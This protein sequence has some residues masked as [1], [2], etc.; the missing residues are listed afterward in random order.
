MS[1]AHWSPS[2]SHA[3]R[4]IRPPSMTAEGDDLTSHEQSLLEL[5]ADRRSSCSP[6]TL[7]DELMTPPGQRVRLAGV[8]TDM[9][10]ARFRAAPA[11]ITTVD[12]LS[13]QAECVDRIG[14]AAQRLVAPLLAATSHLEAVGKALL[15][16]GSFD[17]ICTHLPG[18]LTAL[19]H[20]Y[21]PEGGVDGEGSQRN[22][23]IGTC[24]YGRRLQWRVTRDLSSQRA[25]LV[26]MLRQI[27]GVSV[28]PQDQL[29][30]YYASGMLFAVGDDGPQALSWARS[31]AGDQFSPM[32]QGRY[33]RQRYAMEPATLIGW[34]RD[35]QQPQQAAA[36]GSDPVLFGA[37]AQMAIAG[38]ATN[39]EPLTA[40]LHDEA[41]KIMARV[42]AVGAP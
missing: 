41:C 11:S 31:I 29:R 16:A 12:T 26:A 35:Q 20:D 36:I 33:V 38:R 32:L 21:W 24:G 25:S 8:I 9:V 40:S 30:N 2:S 28:S 22:G 37:L 23:L 42:T 6:T 10:E 14:P 19:S 3:P 18:N 15:S 5:L 39:G 17:Q 34:M 27:D 7:I 13:P 1:T 4:H